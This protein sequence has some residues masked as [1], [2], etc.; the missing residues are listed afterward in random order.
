[1]R[2]WIIALV[3]ALILSS[4]VPTVVGAVDIG[5][6]VSVPIYREKS[7]EITATSAPQVTVSWFGTA[8]WGWDSLMKEYLLPPRGVG[9]V[10]RVFPNIDSI[11]KKVL[12]VYMTRAELQESFVDL[13]SSEL[14][15]LERRDG[16]FCDNVVL[17]DE[18]SDPQSRRYYALVQ[19]GKRSD[20]TLLVLLHWH[21]EK[22]SSQLVSEFRYMAWEWSGDKPNDVDEIVARMK[23]M[24]SGGKPLIE[25][26][27]PALVST[28]TTT[29][30]STASITAPTT[31]S[32][33][34]D[35]Q[36]NTGSVKHFTMTI[37]ASRSY[38]LRVKDR[39]NEE[40]PRERDFPSNETRQHTR[41]VKF[42]VENS[43]VLTYMIVGR[44]DKYISTSEAEITEVL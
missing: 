25:Y 41:T 38:V 30:T 27:P 9:A 3:M 12:G 15:P 10:L 42:A 4:L 19:D 34:L 20:H 2:K 35:S 6:G 11:N 26:T 16:R 23:S 21:R 44:D 33:A 17:D 32:P 7:S 31:P 8:F 22:D 5:Y 24:G 37:K 43:D 13:R 29:T 28:S 1:M 39:L 14:Q 36:S 18:S 40:N